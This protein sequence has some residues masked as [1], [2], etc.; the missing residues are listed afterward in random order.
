LGSVSFVPQGTTAY[1]E[2]DIAG[3]GSGATSYEVDI[4]VNI[5]G[6]G[7]A[8]ANVPAVAT[9]AGNVIWN[10]SRAFPWA[11]TAGATNTATL[12]WRVGASGNSASVDLGNHP[13]THCAIL[14]VQY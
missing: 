7:V 4:Y 14:A 13:L 6:T 3:G 8:G 2:Y 12:E 11:V 1:F 10:S 9:T 5:N